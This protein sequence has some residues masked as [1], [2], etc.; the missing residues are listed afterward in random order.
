MSLSDLFGSYIGS[1]SSSFIL[2]IFGSV[3]LLVVIDVLLRFVLGTIS[4][5]FTFRGK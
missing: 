2:E 4:S 1:S 5:F 3:L